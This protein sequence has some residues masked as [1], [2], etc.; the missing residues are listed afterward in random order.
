MQAISG[1]LRPDLARQQEPRVMTRGNAEYLNE[2]ILD[3]GCMKTIT[4]SCRAFKSMR[5][6]LKILHL[7]S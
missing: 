3:R 7:E 1:R 2:G 4:F 6:Q 5:D